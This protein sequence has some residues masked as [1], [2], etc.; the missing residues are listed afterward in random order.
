[1]SP[2]VVAVAVAVAVG[3]KVLAQHGRWERQ[4]RPRI[5]PH[6]RARATAAVPPPRAPPA[7]V[8]GGS[9]PGQGWAQ[10]EGVVSAAGARVA[11]SCGEKGPKEATGEEEEE[12][13][14]PPVG[15][16]RSCRCAL[17]AAGRPGVPPWSRAR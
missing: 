4:G 5:R 15:L 8:G 16:P 10:G 6:C 12:G 2:V 14:R 11:T 13:L 9:I 3:M 1:M 17:P 7:E